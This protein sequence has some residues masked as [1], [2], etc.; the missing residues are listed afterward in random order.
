MLPL[1]PSCRAVVALLLVVSCACA[2]AP[3]A[4]G[5]F[6]AA[7]RAAGTPG[8]LLRSEPLPGSPP[9]SSA[10]KILY[11]STGLDGRRIDVSGVVIAP[12]LPPP[13]GGRSVVAWAHP[14]TGVDDR[15][16]P[17]NWPEFFETVPHLTALI[18]LD[19]VVVATD[20]AGLGTPGPHPYLVGESEGRAVLDSVRAAGAVEK[21]HA[22]S[23]FAAWGH[24]QGG[25]AALFTGQLAAR[26]APELE[27]VGIAAIAPATDLERLLRDDLSERAGRV[28][29]SYS[30]WAWS[31]V[32]SAS[33]LEIVTSQEISV[34]DG[35]ARDCVE[36]DG[37]VY[38]V[39]WDSRDLRAS[40]L[41]ESAYSVQP[42]AR[43]MVQ[44]RPGASR[45]GAPLYIAQGTADTI[46]RPSA[47]SDFVRGLCGRGEIVQFDEL[48]GVSHL[49]A[50]RASATAA[51][52][53]IRDRFDG[54][55]PPNTCRDLTGPGSGQGSD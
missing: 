23:R 9:G 8:E 19:Y 44:N 51:I 48:P 18:A 16:A 42:W 12:D 20:Y 55:P 7:P 49:R 45:A 33:L 50:G 32:Y 17:S 46:V 22:G 24:S 43:L 27:L 37:E 21:A 39:G 13:D 26:Y 36:S 41:E 4:P 25:H 1:D 3:S 35:V 15:C 53:W 14:T 40:L 2:G 31:R 52:Q 47:T 6:Y 34:I 5:A 28:I 29:A 38:R 30:L 54:K 10:W 11:V